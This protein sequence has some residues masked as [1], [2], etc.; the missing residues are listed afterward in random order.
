M[1]KKKKGQLKL[2]NDA[3]VKWRWLLWLNSYDITVRTADESRD[4]A[5]NAE[6]KH[7]ETSEFAIFGTTETLPD[8][9]TAIIEV[10]ERELKGKTEDELDSIACHEMVHVLMAPFSDVTWE[11]MHE[12]PPEKREVY[13]TWRRK[14][15]EELTSR[16]ANILTAL[17]RSPKRQSS[18]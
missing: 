9:Q 10:V 13:K 7:G 12:L 4:K 18:R 15:Q 11:M 8:Y 2:F 17:H 5:R 1:A 6:E 16:L 3:V 14:A